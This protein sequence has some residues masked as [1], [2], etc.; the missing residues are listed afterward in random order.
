MLTGFVVQSIFLELSSRYWQWVDLSTIVRLESQVSPQPSLLSFLSMV[1][2]KMI[3]QSTVTPGALTWGISNLRI[4]AFL[5]TKTLLSVSWG[6]S[7]SR[8]VN[9]D[10][11]EIEGCCVGFATVSPPH[12]LPALPATNL[13]TS[14]LWFQTLLYH[15]ERTA[16]CQPLESA[17]AWRAS[18]ALEG[19]HGQTAKSLLRDG[20]L[21]GG[22]VLW[23]LKGG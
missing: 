18:L 14:A 17:T 8:D 21:G 11:E 15:T 20:K 2:Q 23:S 7:P 22:E 19:L 9:S 10:I 3:P 1:S 5:L 4:S 16:Q 12:L 6:I 13:G